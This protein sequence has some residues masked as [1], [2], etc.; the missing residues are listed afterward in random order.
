MGSGDR[1]CLGRGDCEVVTACHGKSVYEKIDRVELE[2]QYYDL[3]TS[4]KARNSLIAQVDSVNVKY[5]NS[6]KPPRV[7]QQ[8][9]FD[10]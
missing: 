4:A 1:V 5:V 10:L 8:L 3:K 7:L 9:F 6:N 2:V